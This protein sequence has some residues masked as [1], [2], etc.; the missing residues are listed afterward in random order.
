M[1]SRKEND[2]SNSIEH[3]LVDGYRGW[4]RG[5]TLNDPRYWERSWSLY[6]L[7]LGEKNGRLAMDALSRFVQTMD[8]CST[9]PLK[10]NPLGST[11]VCRD[12]ILMLAL[13]SGLQHDDE[14]VV[15]LCLNEISCPSRCNEISFAA[16]ALATTFNNIGKR[17]R[18][19]PLLTIMAILSEGISDYVVQ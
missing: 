6:T 1:I 3:L 19:I 2:T 10:T 7:A 9:C 8:K 4:S 13:I 14:T 17:L 15:A 5:N 11:G 12:E 16:E 18:P